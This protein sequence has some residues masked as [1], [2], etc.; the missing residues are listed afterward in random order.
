MKIR[1]YAVAA[2]FSTLL[3]VTSI[4]QAMSPPQNACIERVNF[5]VGVAPPPQNHP[6]HPQVEEASAG[7]ILFWILGQAFEQ[8]RHNRKVR[9]AVCGV[10]GAARDKVAESDMVRSGAKS[11]MA[12]LVKEL[13]LTIGCD[14]R[15]TTGRRS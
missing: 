8:L 11:A 12:E 10:L 7:P 2:S 4:A 15:L 3:W 14:F 13:E 5:E 1:K 6:T 9:E